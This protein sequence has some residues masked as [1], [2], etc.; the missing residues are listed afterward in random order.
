MTYKTQL[1]FLHL[2]LNYSRFQLG[3]STGI[4]WHL[5]KY[6]PTRYVKF[7]YKL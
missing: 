1:I 5:G 6:H 2:L 3:T 4:S 7:K